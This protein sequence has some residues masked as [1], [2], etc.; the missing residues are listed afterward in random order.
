[1]SRGWNIAGQLVLSALLL[2]GAMLLG[3]ST[4]P[5]PVLSE[6]EQL[7]LENIQLKGAQLQTQMKDL[8]EQFLKLQADYKDLTDQIAR[9]HPG[10]VWNGQALTPA[11]K[12]APTKK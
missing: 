4:P 9:E 7:K 12:E 5:P 8:Q 6:V 11:P 10:F 1:V 3:Q 2:A